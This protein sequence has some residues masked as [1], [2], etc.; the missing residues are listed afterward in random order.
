MAHLRDRRPAR[1]WRDHDGLPDRELLDPTGMDLVLIAS[2][3]TPL[4]LGL[5]PT[6]RPSVC[7]VVTHAA[8]VPA[9]EAISSADSGTFWRWAITLETFPSV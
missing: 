6:R 5:D 4:P 3:A 2:S 8:L 7:C 9:V 1:A